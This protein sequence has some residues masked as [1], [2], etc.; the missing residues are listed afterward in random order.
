MSRLETIESLV[1]KLPCPVCLNARS[2]VQLSCQTPGDPCDIEVVCEHCHHKYITSD[3]PATMMR[4]WDRVH[5]KIKGQGCPEC[6]DA[7]LNLE[8]LCDTKSED[9]YF[10]VQCEK[11][12]HYS[13]IDTKGIRYLFT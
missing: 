7:N 4:V 6:G 12:N 3:E 9:C 11:N 1:G 5:E 13:R 8:F 10:L 2:T